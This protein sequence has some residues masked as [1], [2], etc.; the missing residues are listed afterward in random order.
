MDF[1][2]PRDSRSVLRSGDRYTGHLLDILPPKL[3]QFCP[4]R[5][6]SLNSQR[7][8]RSSGPENFQSSAK[9]DWANS[10][11]YNRPTTVSSIG[12]FFPFRCRLLVDTPEKI[13]FS[14][15]RN[16]SALPVRLALG[17][18]GTSSI[19][20]KPTSDSR[21]CLTKAPRGRDNQKLTFARP[22]GPLDFRLFQYQHFSD[23]ARYLT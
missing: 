8:T 9:K 22:L 23:L 5:S 6:R 7:E 3:G 19:H 2:K 14:Y 16:F 18:V 11:G 17:D 13:L 4:L 21:T 1:L 12:G 10:P 15:E 20:A